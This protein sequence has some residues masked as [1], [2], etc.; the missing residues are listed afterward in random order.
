MMLDRAHAA[1]GIL[2]Q[3]AKRELTGGSATNTLNCLR[4]SLEPSSWELIRRI[5]NKDLRAGFTENTVNRIA[6]G[7]IPKFEV[8]LAHKY[9]EKR[10]KE[11]PVAVEPKLDGVRTLGLIKNDAAK[12]YSR[13]GKE[14]GALAHLGPHVAKM[15]RN[16]MD[17]VADPAKVRDPI[18]ADTYFSWLGAATT[19]PT[20]AIDAEVIAGNSFNKTSGDV[21]RK[22]EAANDA[23]LNIFDALPLSFVLS[24][25]REWEIPYDVRRNFVEFL[26]SCAEEGAPIVATPHT[27]AASNE[28][29]QK[30]YQGY[31]DLG[32]EGAMVK[33]LKGLYSKKRSHAWLKMKAEETIDLI[34][35][36][37]YEGEGKYAGKLGGL[38]VGGEGPEG[39]QIVSNIGGG[40][41]DIE[42]DE[43]WTS[44]LS[45]LHHG[46]EELFGRMIEIE[47]HEI[48]PDNSLRHP[49][50]VRFRDDKAPAKEEAA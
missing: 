10:I 2:D 5:L 35:T 32:L 19:N 27:T 43:L 23:V 13:T 18:I 15:V 38:V 1:W 39:R 4:A 47:Y 7:T 9:E 12:F 21:R 25:D 33:P 14:F 46:T 17:R 50:F 44:Y 11:W 49:R 42:R 45:D 8:M 31:R 28:A 34:I 36:G 22:S 48:T 24:S 26:V 3:L 16:A 41:S 37:A 40:F 20:L 30:L 6:P 29:I